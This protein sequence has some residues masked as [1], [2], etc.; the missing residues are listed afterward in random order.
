M[1]KEDL[2]APRPTEPAI[3]R[4][5]SHLRLTTPLIALYDTVPSPDF[6]PL[7]YPKDTDCCFCTLSG[8]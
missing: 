2:N 7:V 5:R 6:E 8:G 3:E 4:L 1:K